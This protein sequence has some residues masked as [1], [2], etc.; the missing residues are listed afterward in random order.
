MNKTLKTLEDIRKINASFPYTEPIKKWKDEGKKVVGYICTYIPEE[1]IYAAEV[2]PIRITGD[3]EQSGLEEASAY[4]H[5]YTCSFARSCLELAL[6]NQYGFLDGFVGAS[7]CDPIR[8]LA[9][10][11]EI[12]IPIPFFFVF[13]VPKRFDH[14]AFSLYQIQVERFKEKFE[15]FMGTKITDESLRDAIRV[16]NRNRELLYKLF[17]LRRSDNPP[18]SGA[19]TLEVINA[20]F[21]M[22]K[23]QHNELLERLLQECRENHRALAESHPYR[24]MINGSPLNNPEFIKTIEDLGGLV[25][26]DELCT[27]ARYFWDQVDTSL[28]PLEALAKRYLNHFPC[29]RMYPCEE[30]FKRVINL[31]KDYKV[32]GVITQMVRYCTPYTRDQVLLR[33]RLE[34]EGI[35]VLSLDVEYGQGGVGAVRTRVQAF[36]EIL[37]GREG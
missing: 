36:L 23:E 20:G 10:Y 34:K 15:E 28:P 32:Q 30:R 37:K 21:R 11:W 17:E 33:E 3:S 7:T 6:K 31:A 16:Y 4:M 1:I 12:Y 19:E 35:P 25:V 27:G 5:I 9:D 2:L 22:P 8:R 13:T 29:A 18:I 24:L 14:G 26:I